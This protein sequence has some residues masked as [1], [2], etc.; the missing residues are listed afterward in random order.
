LASN[1]IAPPPPAPTTPGTYNAIAVGTVLVNDSPVSPD[2]IIVLKIGDVVDVTNGALTMTT[3]DGSFLT[4]ASSEI[5]PDGTLAPPSSPPVVAQFRV[6]QGT[7]TLLTL[8]G[9]DFS[10]CTSPRKT[11]AANKKTVR[12]LW[13]SGKGNFSMAGK[14]AVATVRG[15]IWL[16]Q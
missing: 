7:G 16:V 4:L 9:G 6:D 14:F 10:A 1:Q 12:H 11:S 3:L 13:G 2:Q 5:G 15:T 8:V